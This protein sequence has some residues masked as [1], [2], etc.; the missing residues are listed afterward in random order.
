MTP[1]RTPVA[2]PR[3]A[4]VG[5]LELV[6]YT[7]I[8]AIFIV[9]LSAIF[10][11]SIQAEKNARHR[12]QVTGGSQL[13]VITLQAGIRNASDVRV[14]DNRLDA[15]VAVDDDRWECQAWSL[16]DDAIY[17]RRADTPIPAGEP[18]GPVDGWKSLFS[19]SAA[20]VQGGFTGGKAFRRNETP[21]GVRLDVNLE[22]T[23][24]RTTVVI[25]DSV[26][27]QA[28]GEGSPVSCW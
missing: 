28:K 2:H 5:L 13:A 17:F 27:A 6:V 20:R 15:R 21:N 11:T 19:D 3:D 23:Q 10:I 1:T 18:E 12:D 25:T 22:L 4:G 7:A 8:S 26:I 24:D 16:S 14:T 9:A